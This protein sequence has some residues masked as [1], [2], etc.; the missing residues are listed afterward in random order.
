MCP[1]F[2]ESSGRRA[3]T[4]NWVEGPSRTTVPRLTRPRGSSIPAPGL[5]AALVDRTAAESH[6]KSDPMNHDPRAISS[7]NLLAEE[8]WLRGL[9]GRMV[10]ASDVDDVVQDTWFEAIRRPRYVT[11]S[12]RGWLRTVATRLAMRRHRSSARRERRERYATVTEPTPPTDEAVQW[13]EVRENVTNAVLELKEPYRG[14]LLL[15]FYEGLSA[16]EIAERTATPIATVRIRLQRGMQCMRDAMARRNGKDW[17]AGLAAFAIPFGQRAA[18]VGRRS[19]M[20]LAAATIG[21]SALVFFDTEAP[22]PFVS[23]QLAGTPTATKRVNA[24]TTTQTPE[25]ATLPI[26]KHTPAQRRV[27]G[28]VLD[29]QGRPVPGAEIVF[30]RILGETKTTERGRQVAE[31]ENHPLGCADHNGNFDLWCPHGVGGLT[32]ENKIVALCLWPIGRGQA[33]AEVLQ[34]Q[35]VAAP[36]VTLR[37]VIVDT[38]QRGIAKVR[39]AARCEQL[40]RFPRVLDRQLFVNPIAETFTD[41]DGRFV[42]HGF[43]LGC[44]ASLRLDRVGFRQRTVI[45]DSRLLELRVELTRATLDDP[46]R[47]AGRVFDRRGRTIRAAIV[48][49]AAQRTL[50]GDGGRFK[51]E[52]EEIADDAILFAGK[53]GYR[54]AVE[55]DIAKRLREHRGGTLYVD[56]T[57]GPP[58]RA[59]AGVITDGRGVPLPDHLVFLADPFFVDGKSLTAEAL[60]AGQGSHPFGA[61]DASDRAGK[62]VIRGLDDRSYDLRVY[63]PESKN[64]VDGGEHVAGTKDA[65]VTLHHNRFIT[66][67]GRLIDDAGKPIAKAK[68]YFGCS[69]RK[70]RIESMRL[71]TPVLTDHN[72]RFT[73]RRMPREG[74]N[75]YVISGE[76]DEGDPGIVP[77]IIPLDQNALDVEELEFRVAR[78]CHFRIYA[79]Q[80]PAKSK[81]YLLDD[82]GQRLDIIVRHATGCDQFGTWTLEGETT[83]V[84][85]ASQRAHTIVLENAD[86]MEISRTRIQLMPGYIT[87]IDL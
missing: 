58:P 53:Q 11:G 23:D 59:I 78:L 45:P 22:T 17:R 84:L 66:R 19:A 55:R 33:D 4:D 48:G 69:A 65:K 30:R 72:G 44:P 24:N 40:P 74:G 43:P 57:L 1:I 10:D 61:S 14:T 5:P 12:V 77:T 83:Q 81:V 18:V 42:I 9:I 82:Y 38:Q 15:R 7:D 27:A 16:R 54:T 46:L 87:E 49:I 2:P 26:R 75:V 41:A 20:L 32:A 73:L 39:I 47:I 21:V 60:A 56:L 29:P 36:A 6:Y 63:D 76:L 71:R 37:G 31:I 70:D 34:A 8:T 80:A 25:R 85:C 64:A 35:I 68:V 62:F 51:L 3:G 52:L 86:G 50:S 67:P 79:P 13:A 28:R